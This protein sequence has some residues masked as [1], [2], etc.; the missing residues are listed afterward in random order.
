M[1]ICEKIYENKD[2]S[3]FVMSGDIDI[4]NYQK[5]SNILNE[6]S[7]K[8]K[9]V[10]VDLEGIDY[11]DTCGL[12]TFVKPL[13]NPGKILL[14]NTNSYIQGIFHIIGLDYHYKKLDEKYDVKYNYPELDGC[15]DEMFNELNKHYEKKKN[16]SLFSTINGKTYF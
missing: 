3:A 1:A 11:I 7:K 6:E 13:N 5:I 4:K 10:L 2:V 15:I 14:M 9:Y 8:K 12:S 16:P